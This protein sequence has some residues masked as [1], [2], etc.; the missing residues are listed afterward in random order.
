ML[1]SRTASMGKRWDR[2]SGLPF[3]GSPSWNILLVRQN[4][5]AYLTRTVENV[6]EC[7]ITAAIG[8]CYNK[9]KYTLSCRLDQE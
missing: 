4:V 2:I 7:V 3:G 6:V 8:K 5:I 9:Y 1:C